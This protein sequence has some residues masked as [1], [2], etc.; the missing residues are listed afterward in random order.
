VV[1]LGEKSCL[2]SAVHFVSSSSTSDYH[3][4]LNDMIE[5]AQVFL[6]FDDEWLYRDKWPAFEHA[7]SVQLL[8][9][10]RIQKEVPGK[11]GLF[12]ED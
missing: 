5:R 9:D 11:P 6:M 10:C 12:F 1:V 2:E 3:R 4:R 7:Q 8:K